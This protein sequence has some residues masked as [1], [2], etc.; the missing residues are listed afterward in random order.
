MNHQT[1]EKVLDA[2]VE[3][4]VGGQQG[5]FSKT[6]VALSQ[7]SVLLIS[8]GS[9]LGLLPKLYGFLLHG[10]SRHYD[11][12]GSIAALIAIP[13]CLLILAASSAVLFTFGKLIRA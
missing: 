8:L 2:E 10:Y 7:F 3:R 1:N 4:V 12:V 9:T 13:L 11:E 5:C 6:A